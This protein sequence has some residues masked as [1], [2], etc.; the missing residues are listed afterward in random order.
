[1]GAELLERVRQEAG[2]SQ[3]ALASRAG[4][5]RPTLSAYEHGRKSPTLATVERLLDSAGF[6]LT[7]EPKVTFRE[8]PLR[9]GRPI[10][11]AD[12]L[13]RLAIKDAFAE[14][15]LPLELNWLRPGATFRLSDRRQRARCYEVV[16]R[17][18]MPAD[19][20]RYVDGALLVDLWL[21]LVLPRDIRDAWQPVIA[22]AT[23]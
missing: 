22:E 4:T 2:L 18:G 1:M 7:A 16:L 17:E 19:I 11:V 3:E 23:G 13:W 15:T 5:S 14:V 9:R 20:L 12:R 8:V 21:E 6:E 10:F